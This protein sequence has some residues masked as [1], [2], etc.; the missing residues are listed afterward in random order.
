MTKIKAIVEE[1]IIEN[2]VSMNE[3]DNRTWERRI[4]NCIKARDNAED[5]HIKQ[6]WDN[7]LK[8]IL[9]LAKVK[10]TLIN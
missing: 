3:K 5:K 6:T 2:E 4:D 10:T 8:S 1:I 9:R 7:T